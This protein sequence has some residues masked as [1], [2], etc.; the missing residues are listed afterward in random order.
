MGWCARDALALI[1]ALHGEGTLSLSDREEHRP[2]LFQPTD[3]RPVPP[4]LGALRD[5]Y[6]DLAYIQEF[7]SATFGPP[8]DDFSAN[9]AA[10]LAHLAELLRRERVTGTVSSGIMVVSADA[11]PHLRTARSDITVTHKLFATLFGREI[12]VAER[13]M[14]LPPM[15]V[16][17]ATRRRDGEWEVGLVPISGQRAPA[18]VEF[19]RPVPD[20]A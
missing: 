11:L 19:L 7:A 4:G 5:V 15:H 14:H 10:Q 3:A 17:S 6:R 12:H 8:P 2:T 20:R 18:D 9:E 16:R 13:V 1:V